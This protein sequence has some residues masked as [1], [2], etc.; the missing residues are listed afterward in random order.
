[1]PMKKKKE[2][3]LVKIQ[4]NLMEFQNPQELRDLLDGR[5]DFGHRRDLEN[6]RESLEIIRIHRLFALCFDQ[7][8]CI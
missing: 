7:L 1:M 4:G 3:N 2:R 6:V 8:L 5:V